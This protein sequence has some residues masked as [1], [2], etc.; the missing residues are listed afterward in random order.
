VTAACL[1]VK[2]ETFLKV[3]GFDEIWYPIA[4]SDTDLA[5]RVRR[6]GLYS[7]YT[8]FASGVHYESA[9][10]G[11]GVYEEPEASYWHYRSTEKR[12]I[13][14]ENLKH[15]VFLTDL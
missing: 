10:R 12:N 8:P 6:L 15:H 4:F 3:G 9:S 13:P 14:Q 11:P 1:L 7:L 5:M 2:K